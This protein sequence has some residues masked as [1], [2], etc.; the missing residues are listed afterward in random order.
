MVSSSRQTTS[1]KEAGLGISS[2]F[3]WNLPKALSP[4][5]RRRASSKEIKVM[6]QEVKHVLHPFDELE[7][8]K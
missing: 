5:L 7:L 4:Y 6:A 8:Q 1:E 3:P 2:A